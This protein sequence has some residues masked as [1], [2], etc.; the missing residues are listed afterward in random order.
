MPWKNYDFGLPW[1]E[2][3]ETWEP[4]PRM[5][6]CQKAMLPLLPPAMCPEVAQVDSFLAGDLG[7]G[8]QGGPSG[9]Y[10]LDIKPE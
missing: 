2:M 7:V 4:C 6:H 1:H 3:R 5:V 10:S 9:G 8:L